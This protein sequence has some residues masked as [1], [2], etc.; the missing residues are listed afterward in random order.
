MLHLSSIQPNIIVSCAGSTRDGRS[1]EVF[2][3]RLKKIGPWTRPLGWVIWHEYDDVSDDI[4][5]Y[6]ISEKWY[7]M[8]FYCF[9][10]YSD[11]FE[12]HLY[13]KEFKARDFWEAQLSG[14]APQRVAGSPKLRSFP[15]PEVE[16]DLQVTKTS[17]EHCV[18]HGGMDLY[19]Y[20]W[21]C[22][23]IWTM[24]YSACIWNSLDLDRLCI[25]KYVLQAW[26]HTVFMYTHKHA[27]SSS[28]EIGL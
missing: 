6:L 8:V 1:S 7:F 20:V 22:I 3:W 14:D 16:N 25:M 27:Q 12:Y 19:K 2:S 17:V 4:S 15:Y 21:I 26:S 11:Y 23:Y 18:S 9:P 5:R 13:Y 28:I 10:F 24:M